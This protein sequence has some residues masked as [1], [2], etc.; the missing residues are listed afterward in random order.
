MPAEAQPERL[1]RTLAAPT[2]E[3][4]ATAETVDAAAFITHEYTAPTARAGVAAVP[5]VT[6]DDVVTLGRLG[7]LAPDV[8]AA[9]AAHVDGLLANLEL[10]MNRPL[11]VR[12]FTDDVKVGPDGRLWLT[13]SP[14]Q[15]VLSVQ[16]LDWTGIVNLS[17]IT[18][19]QA[20]GWR[21]GTVIRV[22]YTAGLNQ[23]RY[24]PVLRAAVA[25]KALTWARALIERAA[26]P[27]AATE[28]GAGALPVPAPAPGVASFSV[29]GLNVTYRTDAE[30]VEAAVRAAQAEAAAAVWTPEELASL[31]HLRRVVVA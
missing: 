4:V 24:A 25:A 14:V 28:G 16:V 22:R 15:Q 10:R 1:Q 8:R 3:P 23:D 29:E 21:P 30:A 20:Y 11:S 12:E 17:A 19:P 7:D 26:T 31:G 18:D 27:E 6:V 2:V 5:V 9:L 13:Q